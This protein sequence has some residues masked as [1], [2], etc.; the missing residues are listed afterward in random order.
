MKKVL[1]TVAGLM[2]AVVVYQVA[3]AIV[4]HRRKHARVST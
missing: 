4:K 1:F 2:G 3:N